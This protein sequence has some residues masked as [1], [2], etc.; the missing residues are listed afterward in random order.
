MCGGGHAQRHAEGFLS[1][2][3]PGVLMLMMTHDMRCDI[4]QLA[5]GAIHKGCLRVKKRGRLLRKLLQPQLSLGSLQ[6]P[7]VVLSLL[8]DCMTTMWTDMVS[9]LG[10]RP[11]TISP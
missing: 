8:H 6:I 1:P 9:E 7:P 5:R 11:E 2:D 3:E 10:R 4:S